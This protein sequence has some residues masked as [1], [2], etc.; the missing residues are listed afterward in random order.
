MK[1]KR[2][3]ETWAVRMEHW[4]PPNMPRPWS[5]I[6]VLYEFPEAVIWR[7]VDTFGFRTRTFETRKQARK[8][9]RK[10]ESRPMVPVKVRI[11][12]EEI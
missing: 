2:E 7:H 3:M 4:N 5:F 6:G 9:C 10:Y 8:F 11:T 12:I 1:L